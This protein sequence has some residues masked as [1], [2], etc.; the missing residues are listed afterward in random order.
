M[1]L[2]ISNCRKMHNIV[3]IEEIRNRERRSSLV[4]RDFYAAVHKWKHRSFK[5]RFRYSASINWFGLLPCLFSSAGKRNSLVSSC[6]QLASK[7]VK[8]LESQEQRFNKAWL[9]FWQA[10]SY[11]MA[12]MSS[13][14]QGSCVLNSFCHYNLSP[15]MD[16]SGVQDEALSKTT[17]RW[18]LCSLASLSGC[19]ILTTKLFLQSQS[20]T[21]ASRHMCNLHFFYQ[22]AWH[23][24]HMGETPKDHII[25]FYFTL[26]MYLSLGAFTNVP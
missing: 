21:N 12:A 18:H 4:C 25:L 1:C 13:L 19:I 22:K 7:I 2:C 26:L 6:L 11:P 24:E 17:P 14:L 5:T 8:P 16:R 10:R 23:R 15:S 3:V 9:L 20:V